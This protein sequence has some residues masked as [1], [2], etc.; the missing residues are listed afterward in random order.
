MDLNCIASQALPPPRSVQGAISLGC[1]PKAIARCRALH[2]ICKSSITATENC[3]KTCYHHKPYYHQDLHCELPHIVARQNS[4]HASLP[5]RIALG[6]VWPK[7]MPMLYH[8]KIWTW[9]CFTLFHP[10]ARQKL[11]RKP[12]ALALMHARHLPKSMPPRSAL[13]LFSNSKPIIE[14]PLRRPGPKR[15]T[16]TCL[17]HKP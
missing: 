7:Y 3:T 10:G 2:Y 17:H 11:H 1:T 9:N 5:P 12:H 8:T 14:S 15:L 13:G 6:S 16:R 4:P